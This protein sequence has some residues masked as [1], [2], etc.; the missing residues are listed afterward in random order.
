MA[1]HHCTV[2]FAAAG[3]K[4]PLT[5]QAKTSGHDYDSFPASST[6][7]F[8]FPETPERGPINFWW[9]DRKGNK[10]TQDI[11][12]YA[13]YNI[14]KLPDGGTVIFG[15]KGI[16]YSNAAYG[17]GATYDFIAPGGVKIAEKEGVDFVQAV[18]Q[19]D[20]D[21]SQMYELF[22]A[23]EANNPKICVSNFIDRAGPMTETVLLGNLAVWAAAQ[24][25]E[26]G[27]MGEWGEK[28]EW[29]AN[30]LVVRNLADLKTPGIADLIKPVY[31]DGYILD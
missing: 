28:V 26:N 22:R 16:Y 19:G 31:G 17:A 11:F 5:V 27:S 20:F 29:D 30:N 4:D 13:K 18:N 9:L 8:E 23:V 24:G 12:D 10:P 3:L 25:G 2:P 15:E 7:K 6:I 14:D 1:C 21:K